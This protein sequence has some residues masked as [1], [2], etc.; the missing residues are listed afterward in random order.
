MNDRNLEYISDKMFHI[1]MV[2]MQL[3]DEVNELEN[4]ID[5]ECL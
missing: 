1:R 3:E 2:L 5:E 4:I